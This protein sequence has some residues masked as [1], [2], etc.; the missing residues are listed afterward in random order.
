MVLRL[1]I[2]RLKCIYR[3]KNSMFWNYMFP[4]ILTTCFFLAFN[5]VMT[6]QSFETISIAYVSEIEGKD[7]FEEILTEVSYGDKRM[8]EVTYAKE[9]E[10]K[11]L[12]EDGKIEAYIVNRSEPELY[13]NQNGFNETII[14]AFLDTYRQ[15][16]FA[17]ESILSQNPKAIEQGLLDDVLDYRTF[18]EEVK[19][20]KKPD[21][22][23][24]YYF[25][26]LAYTCVFATNWG[27]EEVI[28]I[29]ADQSHKGARINVSPIHKMKL[30]FINLTASFTAHI[31][32]LILLFSYMYFVLKI[33]FGI[34]LP[35]LF[36]ICL[37]GTITGLSMGATIGIWV[38]KKAEVKEAI[39]TVVVLFSGFLSGMMIASMKY[40][41][42]KYVPIIQY[43]NPCTLITDAMYSLYY[44]DS[45]DRY[46]LSA[47]L[48]CM[49]TLLLSIASYVGMR[50]KNYASI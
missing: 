14:K 11:K 39:M 47:A 41:V 29:Q 46:Y 49:I 32:S 7:D 26:L 24:V 34:N 37:L 27:L 5:N 17:I 10:A 44:Y 9:S 40:L 20:Q 43:L 21:M 45:Y 23:L 36:F 12:L 50:R 1:Y 8:F 18:V 38:K 3:N 31:G 42:A 28:N 33:D 4:L 13:I 19:G 22:V 15:K 6:T 30:F 35:H 2:A 16:Y 48:L 25:S